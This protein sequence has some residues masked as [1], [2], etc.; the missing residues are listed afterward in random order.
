MSQ[1]TAQQIRDLKTAGHLMSLE[2]GV[3]CVFL[4][5]GSSPPDPETGL[6]G[7]QVTAAPGGER[8][9]V[10]VLTIH[11]DAW[12]GM[13]SAALVRVGHGPAQVL[14]TIYQ[15]PE[16]KHEAPKLQ[17]MKVADVQQAAAAPAAAA[18]RAKAAKAVE[19]LAHVYGR[20]D[21][22][23]MLGE[24]VGEAGSNRWIEGF[25]VAPRNVVPAADIE[26]QAVLGRGWMSPGSEGGQFCGS[27]GMSL[28]I[29]GLKVRLRGESSGRFRTVLS[30]SF[31]DGSW[32]GPLRD[33]QVCEAPSMAALESFLLAF[34]PVQARTKETPAPAKTAPKR[35]AKPVPVGNGRAPKKSP[36]ARR[37]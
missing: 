15:E 14:V 3:Y 19:V 10:S 37:R 1:S 4:T 8:D 33:D 25:A 20:G 11:Q 13:D 18:P 6:P 17:V 26:Y 32:V 7:V 16:T 29:L 31:V 21:V 35:A 28:P 2:A 36:P 5:P 12:I 24:R 27:R 23:G 30:A 22:G 9:S 34:E